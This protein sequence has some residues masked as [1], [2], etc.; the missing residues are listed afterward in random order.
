MRT[1]IYGIEEQGRIAPISVELVDVLGS[2][3]NIVN[4]ARSTSTGLRLRIRV[5]LCAVKHLSSLLA[6]W[7]SI[8]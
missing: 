1:G 7:L 6:N 2:D 3:V 5:L 8:R 4:A